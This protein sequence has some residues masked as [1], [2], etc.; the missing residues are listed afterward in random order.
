M[1]QTKYAKPG[2][3]SKML[4]KNVFLFVFLRHDNNAINSTVD[5]L[6]F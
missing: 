2:R 3:K 1:R 4:V 5:S 6:Y